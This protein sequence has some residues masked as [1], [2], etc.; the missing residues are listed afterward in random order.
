MTELLPGSAFIYNILF[1]RWRQAFSIFSS[2][3]YLESKKLIYTDPARWEQQPNRVTDSV[4]L[5][6]PWR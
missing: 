3:R 5:C 2:F 4:S 1:R 6:T